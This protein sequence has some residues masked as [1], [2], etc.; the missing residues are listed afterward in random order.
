[1]AEPSGTS[2]SRRPAAEMVDQVYVE[3]RRL[4]AGYVRRERAQSVQATDLVHEAY[5]RL[6]HE[7]QPPWHD[8][9]HFVAI[10]AIAMRRLLVERARARGAAKRGGDRLQVTL[11]ERVIGADPK[12][13]APDLLELDRALDKLAT[14]DPQQ[15][16]LVELRYFGGLSVEETADAIGVSPATVKRHWTVAKAWLLRELH[17]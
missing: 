17:G 11:D 9:T 1:M 7:T 12:S 6:Q 2:D 15:A 14:L 16:R 13:E 3:L 8:R 4:A 10:A 5:L